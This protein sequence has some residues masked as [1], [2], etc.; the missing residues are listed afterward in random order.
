MGVGDFAYFYGGG[1]DHAQHPPARRLLEKR[2]AEVFPSLAGV[3]TAHHWGG[4]VSFP[5]D[6]FPAIGYL[7]KDRRVVYSLG[8]MGWGV[9]LATIAGQILRDL[10]REE[11]SELTELPFVNRRVL[12]LP[13][14]PLRFAF[15][16]AVRAALQA[17]DAWGDRRGRRKLDGG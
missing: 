1:L 5:L 7:G 6:F 9:P 3:P 8:Y 4:P 16:Q 15:V 12:P 11:E 13:P 14:E 17:E 10:V 2:I